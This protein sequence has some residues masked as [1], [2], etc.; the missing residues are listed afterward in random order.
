MSVESLIGNTEAYLHLDED[1]FD[2]YQR[3]LIFAYPDIAD[4]F[5]DVLFP[6]QLRWRAH[7]GILGIDPFGR[8]I[9]APAQ[10]MPKKSATKSEYWYMMTFT[11]KPSIKSKGDIKKAYDWICKNVINDKLKPIKGTVYIVE[12]K[13]KSGRPHWHVRGCYGVTIKPTQ[14]KYYGVEKKPGTFGIVQFD[15]T[16][17]GNGETSMTYISK[18]GVPSLL[19]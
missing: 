4:L 1:D 9:Y 12:E 10:A 18:E 7:R 3:S 13:H 2:A 14:F 17:T 11:L 5:W 8:Y 19:Y 16:K 6:Q 15:K